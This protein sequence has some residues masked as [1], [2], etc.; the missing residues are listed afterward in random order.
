MDILFKICSI[1][2]HALH[3]IDFQTAL[4]KPFIWEPEPKGPQSPAGRPVERIQRVCE[5]RP[6]RGWG[7][8]GILNFTPVFPS[9]LN[10]GNENRGLGCA[11][12]FVRKR[13]K[14]F[15]YHVSHCRSQNIICANC[16]L[17]RSSKSNVI[18]NHILLLP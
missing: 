4:C 3:I 9:I 14:I 13:Q 15:S 5:L 2:T 18:M 17:S 8:E 11:R 16:Y 10:T 1:R 12:D 6:G 7:W